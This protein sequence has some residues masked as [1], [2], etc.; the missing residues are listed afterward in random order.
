M[1]GIDGVNDTVQADFINNAPEITLKL[2]S[3]G[4]H[5]NVTFPQYDFSF[6]M[7]VALKEDSLIVEIPDA[8]I[9]ENSNKYMIPF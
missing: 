5:A 2:L 4:F 3:N 7:T 8:T 1:V 6:E 9:I